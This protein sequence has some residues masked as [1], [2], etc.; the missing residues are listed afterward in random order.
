M[1]EVGVPLVN[2]GYICGSDNAHRE[3]F[4]I[5]IIP[6]Q[7]IMALML[8]FPGSRQTKRRRLL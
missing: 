2:V 1:E 3:R 5:Q 4:I 6:C 7:D 8:A